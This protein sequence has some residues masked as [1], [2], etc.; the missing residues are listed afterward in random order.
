MFKHCH[1]LC[2]V[3]LAIASGITWGLGVL[4]L[5]YLAGH[6]H[7]GEAAVQVMGSVY[8]GFEATSTA[9][10]LWG[11]LWGLIDGFVGGL[12]FAWIY[13]LCAWCCGC[14]C[15]GCKGSKESEHKEIHHHHK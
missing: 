12:I 7:W 5:G 2:P 9:G 3:S 14:L 15:K 10:I 6:H 1:K 8:K 11:G 4:I 13:N